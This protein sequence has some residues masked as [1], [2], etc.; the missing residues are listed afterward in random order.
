MYRK[1]NSSWM[2]HWDFELLDVVLMEF[3]FMISYQ[4]R[5]RNSV[6][7]PDVTLYIRLALVL[8]AFDIVVVFF[9][10]NYKSILQRERAKEFIE[11]IKHVTSIYLLLLLY[12]Y[13]IKETYLF[14]RTVFF[15]SWGMSIGMCYIGRLLLKVVVRSRMMDERNQSK[16]LV[17]STAEHVGSCINQIQQKEFRE[18]RISA[19]AVP[20]QT[21]REERIDAN[22]P[23]LYGEFTLIDYIRQNVVDEIFIDTFENKNKLNHMVTLFLSMGITVHINMGFLPDDLP[24]RFVEKIGQC[25]VVTTTMKAASSWRLAVKRLVDIIGALVGLVITGIAYVFVAPAIKHASPGPVIFKQK[26]VGR[27]GRVFDM[28][29]FRSMYLDAEERIG[30]L[31]EQNE[32]NGLMFKMENDPRIIGSEK[33]PGKGIGNFIRRTSIDELPQFWNILKGEMSLVG[34]RPPTYAEYEKYNLQHKI[35]LSMLPGLTGL[36]QVSGRSDI[37]DFDEVV[38]L[39]AEYIEK[40]SLRM[41]FKILLKTVKVVFQRSGSK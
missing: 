22:I 17:I 24:N 15:L 12:E 35:R 5:H 41:D 20:E 10:N 3:A 2:K 32:M 14:S 33:G 19:I 28:Y 4:L 13:L 31:M 40:W 16:M 11:V 9:S 26:R 1:I 7:V 39:D 34:T 6:S 37:T 27:N 30:E 38:R 25:H 18:F 23:I 8:L 36:W 29:K 21:D